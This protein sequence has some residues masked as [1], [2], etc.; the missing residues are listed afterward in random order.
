MDICMY[1]LNIHKWNIYNFIYNLY[2]CV[3]FLTKK[4]RKSGILEIRENMKGKEK[5]HLKYKEK[6]FGK[7]M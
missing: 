7:I 3:Y 5:I 6:I 2:G 1:N 4:I